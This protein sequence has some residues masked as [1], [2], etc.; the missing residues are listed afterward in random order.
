VQKSL[1]GQ[2]AMKHVMRGFDAVYL[3][4][5]LVVR[6]TIPTLAFTSFDGRL[7]QAAT[8]EGLTVLMP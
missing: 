8:Q 1:A 4:A 6:D 2:L 7:D 3:A 5:A